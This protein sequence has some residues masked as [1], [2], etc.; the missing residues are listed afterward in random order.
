LVNKSSNSKLDKEKS[1]QNMNFILMLSF[2]KHKVLKNSA[3][4]Y[5]YIFIH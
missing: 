1:A 2:Q 3:Y 5:M 4:I